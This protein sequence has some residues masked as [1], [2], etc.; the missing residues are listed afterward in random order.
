MP[1]L[2]QEGGGNLKLEQKT[3]RSIIEKVFSS[4][5]EGR[6]HA[7]DVGGSKK[8]RKPGLKTKELISQPWHLIERYGRGKAAGPALPREGYIF[9]AID[10]S[11]ELL[12]SGEPGTP[13]KRSEKRAAKFLRRHRA[14]RNHF[15]GHGSSSEDQKKVII[16]NTWEK[17]QRAQD[18]A[19]KHRIE[20]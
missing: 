20:D 19:W 3:A 11:F 6:F 4:P 17:K 16:E 7:S 8:A 5:G 12:C 2:A 13:E 1:V 14:I 18:R 10:L 15:L 9:P